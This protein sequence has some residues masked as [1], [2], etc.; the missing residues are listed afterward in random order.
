MRRAALP[1]W[2]LAGDAARSS[3]NDCRARSY[4]TE[5]PVERWR[6][7]GAVARPRDVRGWRHLT[8]RDRRRSW[9]PG[10]PGLRA[11]WGLVRFLHGCRTSGLRSGERRRHAVRRLGRSGRRPGG[12]TAKDR[13]ALR[14]CETSFGVTPSVASVSRTRGSPDLVAS[15]GDDRERPDRSG[16]GHSGAHMR[17]RARAAERLSRDPCGYPSCR[18]RASTS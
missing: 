15:P 1:G 7:H 14:L 11:P 17:D 8:P 9:R 13:A 18:S 4:A 12:E 3:A 10:L 5:T 6:C 2:F 16:R